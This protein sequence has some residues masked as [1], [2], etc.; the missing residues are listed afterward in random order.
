MNQLNY[1]HQLRKLYQELGDSFAYFSGGRFTVDNPV[2]P[3]L[4]KGLK[5]RESL[6]T[7][8]KGRV[9]RLLSLWHN[10]EAFLRSI[11][12]NEAGRV[13]INGDLNLSN[14][15]IE[16]FP[17][18]IQQVSGKLNLAD[19]KI[20]ALDHLERVGSLYLEGAENMCSLASLQ[21]VEK[22]L[23]ISKTQIA[24]I[25]QLR[26]VGGDFYAKELASL[27]SLPNL[28]K[29]LGTLDIEGTSIVR[30]PKL[31]VVQSL[32]ANGVNTLEAIPNLSAAAG[33]IEITGTKIKILPELKKVGLSFD[34]TG[35]KTLTALPKLNHV[36]L[37][38]IISGTNVSSLPSLRTVYGGFYAGKAAELSSIP[39]LISVRGHC[40]LSGTKIEEAPLLRQVLQGLSIRDVQFSEF[41]SAFPRLKIIRQGVADIGVYT[42]D[43][44]IAAE[45]EQLVAAAELQL[46]GEIKLDE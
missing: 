10:H 34:A 11:E 3:Q 25:P 46:S 32:F 42:D 19:T 33:S 38:F 8:Y 35:L 37:D 7:L 29:V 43:S 13:V 31:K 26:F 1:C 36:G 4:I 6:F 40:R 30:L 18:L 5:Q 21:T 44:Q 22:D 15:P 24:A 9:K 28:E 17:S 41:S 12:V 16:F 23:L 20:E 45:L 2:S 27:Q 39:E 14:L